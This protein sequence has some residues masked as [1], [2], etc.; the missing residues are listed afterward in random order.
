MAS[1]VAAQRQDVAS[2]LV[3]LKAL[4]RQWHLKQSAMDDALAPFGPKALHS[5]LVSGIAEQEGVLRAME[6]SFLEE[7]GRASEREMA[8]FVKRWRDARKVL[9]LRKERRRRFEEGRVGGWR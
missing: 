8:E 1:A 7:D 3:Q 2:H 5:R 6:E 4:E 9:V